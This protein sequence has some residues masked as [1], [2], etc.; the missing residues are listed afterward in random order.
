MD[1]PGKYVTVGKVNKLQVLMFTCSCEVAMTLLADVIKLQNKE[2][3]G[4]TTSHPS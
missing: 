2:L 1:P 4:W 3:F